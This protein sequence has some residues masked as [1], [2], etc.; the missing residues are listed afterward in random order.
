MSEIG[1]LLI[2]QSIHFNATGVRLIL[3]NDAEKTERRKYR[4]F[5]DVKLDPENRLNLTAGSPLEVT[6]FG[7]GIEPIGDEERDISSEI[8]RL[9]Y[10]EAMDDV[11]LHLP[12]A[13]TAEL[14]LPRSEFDELLY[15]ARHGRCPNLITVKVKGLTTS[16][17]MGKVLEW[18]NSKNHSHILP[19]KSVTFGIP[20]VV[21]PTTDES[22]TA[23]NESPPTRGQLEAVARGLG[24]I[25]TLLKW[26]LAL[27]I[28]AILWQFLR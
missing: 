8:G 18:D 6:R 11:G 19:I 10:S 23:F 13:I 27:S 15:A 16:G 4:L 9:W 12:Q 3:G 5:Y 7:V 25:A 14:T 22:S 26:L 21:S 1:D 20:F 17:F 2:W 24:K 28:G